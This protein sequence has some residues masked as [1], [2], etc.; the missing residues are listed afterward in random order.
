MLVSLCNVG[1]QWD[2]LFTP[3]CDVAVTTVSQPAISTACRCTPGP[4]TA[5]C[6]SL[7]AVVSVTVTVYCLVMSVPSASPRL[8]LD[9]LCV[10]YAH[11]RRHNT[12]DGRTDHVDVY[13]SCRFYVC[14]YVSVCLSVR[15]FVCCSATLSV[16]RG[17]CCS[18]A[19]LSPV[20][21]T[22][23]LGPSTRVVETG[24]YRVAQ[25]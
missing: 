3:W 4:D 8:A 10:L 19:V 6:A 21:T 17:A 24:L 2:R 14:L 18:H 11:S 7:A 23:Q 9:P 1:N 16:W 5:H 12:S 13:V 22:R 20:S 25:K 15:L